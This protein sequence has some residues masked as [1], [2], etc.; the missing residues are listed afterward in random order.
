[1]E[2]FKYL[3]VFIG[4][5]AITA[6]VLIWVFADLIGKLAIIKSEFLKIFGWT[7][8]T[9]RKL[10]VENE[11]Q[12][13]INSILYDYNTNFESPILPNCK[14]QWVTAENQQSFLKDNEAIICLSF[15]KKDHN[16]N[17]YNAILNFAQTGLIPKA[18]NYLNK[19][20]SKAIDLLITHIIL[21]KN[22]KEVL[23]TFHQKFTE[24]D[25][26]TKNE[27]QN[28]VPTNDRGLFLY[29]LLPE[30]YYY[31]ELITT[32]PPNNEFYI[33]AANFLQW[34]KEIATREFDERSNL[35][36]I[37]KN[38]KVG[39]ILIGKEETWAAYGHS[40]YIKWADYY[41]SEN[42]NSVYVLAKGPKWYERSSEV[43]KILINTKGFDQ[44]NK[45][46]KIKCY[47]SE[48]EEY[49]VTCFSLRPNRASIA[50]FA[51]EQL[52]DYFSKKELVPAIIDIVQRDGVF[53]NIFGLKIEISNEALS[54]IIITDARNA[55]NN[56]DELFLNILELD[57][58]KQFV[59][60]S[61][62]GTVSDPKQ[63]IERVVSDHQIITSIIEKIHSDR[64]GTQI[65]LNVS[66]DKFKSWIFIPKYNLTFSRFL[67]LQN[68]YTI[69]QPLNIF[70]ESFHTGSGSFI[71]KLEN[72]T[73]PWDTPVVNKI[74]PNDKVKV[75]VK[76]INEFSVTCEIEE[77]LECRFSKNEISWDFDECDTSKYKVGDII[78]VLITSIDFDKRHI[79]VSPKRLIKTPELIFYENH[80]NQIIEAEI[81]QIIPDKGLQIKFEN[82]SST[83]FI[84]WYEI[85]W[86]P[87]GRIETIFS[88][89]QKVHPILYDFYNDKNRI[90]FSL[91]R[92]YSHQFE[93]IIKT[94]VPEETIEGTVVAHFDGC[95]QIEIT[96]NG[97]TA[98]A[99]IPKKF[100][101][102]IAHIENEDLIY[103]L[104]I[105]KS[106]NFTILS[107]EEQ[108]KFIVLSRKEYLQSF[109]DPDYGDIFDVVL[110][111]LNSSKAFFYS[112]DLEGWVSNQ[113]IISP[114]NSTIRVIPV[115][116]STSE[117]Q[118][119]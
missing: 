100:I 86:A 77:A 53:V 82:G 75:I 70:I 8:K 85:G 34:F 84:H 110:V 71:G 117:Y 15:N 48:G 41:A 81:I 11:F 13:T 43:V 91:K 115:V 95:S 118:L 67:N 2:L 96:N 52:K 6:L 104:P 21:R 87:V 93:D 119:V 42:Y 111:K 14:I 45:T 68:K 33:E 32:L 10:S 16:L 18:K 30:F 101:S 49:F 88:T 7:A 55:F 26:E 9:V 1:M 105:G 23:T 57:A 90:N 51:W 47:N 3:L 108:K 109:E 37:S 63:Y 79:Y 61:N 39:V 38:Y 78:E 103:Y 94:I 97:F 113:K 5:G 54:E 28:L 114:V 83:G 106:F 31:G 4:G 59:V 72:L 74:N 92:K 36:F 27:F 66:N 98:Q 40:A 17:F 65:G 44:I 62:K 58:D 102:N 46:T 12:G 64:Q 73:N 50:Y 25:E 20:S 35:K 19:S 24:F 76:E 107:I 99:F 60:F 116:L 112:N 29:L 69:G 80:V 22:R 89:G 56:N